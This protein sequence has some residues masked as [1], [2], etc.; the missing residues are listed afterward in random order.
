MNTMR[1]HPHEW[2]LLMVMRF[3]EEVALKNRRIFYNS[4]VLFFVTEIWPSAHGDETKSVELAPSGFDV[5]SLPRHSRSRV[6][7]IART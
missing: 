7:G 4:I 1:E 6:S 5:K 2:C 3:S